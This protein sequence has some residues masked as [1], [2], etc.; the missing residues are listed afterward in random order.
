VLCV[1]LPVSVISTNFAKEYEATT[2]RN[3]VIKKLRKERLLKKYRHELKKL[4]V[5]KTIA[6]SS[7]RIGSSR[8][9]VATRE[10]NQQQKAEIK[11]MFALFCVDGADTIGLKQLELALASM[12]GLNITHHK[13]R[14]VIESEDKDFNGR[15]DLQEFE[16]I[17]LRLMQMHAFNGPGHKNSKA[18]LLRDDSDSDSSD[19]SLGELQSEASSESNVPYTA[20]HHH[21]HTSPGHHSS[22]SHHHYHHP[23]SHHSTPVPGGEIEMGDY[24]HSETSRHGH[25]HHSRS[26]SPSH[27]R[28]SHSSNQGGHRDGHRKPSVF[29]YI[30][31][32][33][34]SLEMCSHEQLLD[35]TNKLIAAHENAEELKRLISVGPVNMLSDTDFMTRSQSSDSSN[36]VRPS[37]PPPFSPPPF[38]PPVAA[39]NEIVIQMLTSEDDDPR[40]ELSSS[41]PDTVSTEASFTGS[42]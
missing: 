23:H 35:F 13:L 6:Q 2:Q 26:R 7:R 8:D 5:M 32:K 1:S 19:G 24:E 30:P 18:N 28:H 17:I 11:D 39:N 12:G 41:V 16:G 21:H 22:P 4:S 40:P 27:Q 31:G 34:I 9:E 3:E 38:S 25:H 20:H 33:P 10:W 42:C 37:A 29:I 36:G 14:K 15:I